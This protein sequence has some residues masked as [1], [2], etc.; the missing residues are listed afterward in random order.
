MMNTDVKIISSEAE[1]DAL[2][3]EWEALFARSENASTALDC[4]WLRNWWKVYGKSYGAG[5]RI[6]T[7]YQASKL[8]GV[9]PLYLQRGTRCLRFLGTG[10]HESEEICADYLDLLQAHVDDPHALAVAAWRAIGQ[11]HWDELDLLDMP[12]DSVFPQA[13]PFCTSQRGACPIADLSRGFESYL[14]EISANTRQQARR[15]MRAAERVGARFELAS[16]NDLDAFFSDLV[17]LHQ[18]RW[19]AEG[20]P[21]CFAAK[22]FT[23]FHRQLAQKWVPTGRAVLARLSLGASVYAVLYGFITRS[24]FD[25]Y[26]SGIKHT[27]TDPF[28]SPGTTAHLLLM[29]ALSEQ[30]VLAYDFLRGSHSYKQRLAT[31]SNQLVAIHAWRMTPGGVAGRC[32]NF[33]SRASRR[34]LLRGRR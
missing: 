19:T 10:E 2:E 34:L 30:G 22:R 15:A 5:I 18:S 4:S 1:W 13:S 6:V 21:G 31:R 12:S 29:K 7:L 24:R 23:E 14:A 27:E 32:L 20:K 25:F 26:Q 16:G 11:M 33:V 17:R 8:V 3:P 9:L 28:D